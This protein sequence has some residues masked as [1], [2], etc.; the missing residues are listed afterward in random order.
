[1]KTI[2][3]VLLLC[4]AGCSSQCDCNARWENQIELDKK[5]ADTLEAQSAVDTGLIRSI[6]ILGGL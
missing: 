1:M 5:I 3:L 2:A 4:L 6:E